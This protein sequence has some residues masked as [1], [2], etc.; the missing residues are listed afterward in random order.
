MYCHLH[1]GD[2]CMRIRCVDLYNT[3]SM[4]WQESEAFSFYQ[5]F[6]KK[7]WKIYPKMLFPSEK[8]S[9]GGLLVCLYTALQWNTTL[10]S[11]QGNL[12]GSNK[13]TA[14]HQT[15]HT[16]VLKWLKHS[17]VWKKTKKLH[18][19]LC[20][21]FLLCLNRW[22]LSRTIVFVSFVSPV[23]VPVCVVYLMS[24]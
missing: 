13:N 16:C 21:V 11:Q 4:R 8:V 24:R 3:Q 18:I 17:Q 23:T 14:K 1:T 20:L 9:S 22:A 10:F 12:F 15:F 7:K 19:K 5:D 6:S 2:D